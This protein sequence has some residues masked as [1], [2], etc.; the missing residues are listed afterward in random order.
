MLNTRNIFIANLSV[1]DILLCS[2]SIPLTLMDILTNNWTFGQ[3]MVRTFMLIKMHFLE[4][5]KKKKNYYRHEKVGTN[6][7]TNKVTPF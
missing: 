2:F 5:S 1:S 3:D 7:A 4:T 6:R